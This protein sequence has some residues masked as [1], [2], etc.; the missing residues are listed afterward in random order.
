MR[1][2]SVVASL[3]HVLRADVLVAWRD[4]VAWCTPLLFYVIVVSLFAMV[5]NTQVAQLA[6]FAPLIIWI[7]VLLAALLAQERALRADLAN[8]CLQQL[9]L[10]PLPLS[11]LLLAKVAAHWLSVMLPV[12]VITPL[13]AVLLHV[14]ASLTLMLCCSLLLGTPVI[15]LVGGIGAALTVALP[16]GGIFLA[17]LL[18]PLYVPVLLFGVGMVV[19]ASQGLPVLGLVALLAA[20]L[21]LALSLAP[22]AMAAALRAGLM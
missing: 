19:A 4:R 5:L 21:C 8:G 20:L 17:L 18:L 22:W 7:A 3:G 11:L 9:C 15:S 12:I 16:N 2:L 1:Q 13:F 14:P 6:Q 10:S